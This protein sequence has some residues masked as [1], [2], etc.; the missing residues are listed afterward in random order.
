ML[1]WRNRFTSQVTRLVV[2]QCAKFRPHHSHNGHA[3]ALW[4]LRDIVLLRGFCAR[5]NPP[6]M[7]PSPT[8]TPPTIAT[9]LHVYCAICDA[10]PT[11][12]WYA[13]HHTT[14][15]MANSCEGQLVPS[16]PTSAIRGSNQIGLHRNKALTL[17][18]ALT[19]HQTSN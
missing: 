10:P 18:H 2:L 11:L 12:L 4:P 7:A 17:A 6:F 1:S 3:L 15:V 5:I 16:P 14:L 8:C 19:T 9:L 13:V